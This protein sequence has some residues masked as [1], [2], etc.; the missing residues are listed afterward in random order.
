MTVYFSG[1][2]QTFQLKIVALNYK[3]FLYEIKKKKKIHTNKCKLFAL[4]NGHI[5]VR[6][7]YRFSAILLLDFGKVPT[8]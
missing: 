1:L 2:V 6:W 4:V 5:F 3:N 7:W 8:M